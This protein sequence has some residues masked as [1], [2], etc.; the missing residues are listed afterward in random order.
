MN[1]TT[2]LALLF[3]GLG[4]CATPEPQAPQAP[5]AGPDGLVAVRSARVDELFLRP[6]NEMAG[7]RKVLLDPVVVELDRDWVNQRHGSNYRIQ[8]TYPRYKAPEEVTRETTAA[9]SASLAKA[10]RASGFEVVETPGAD[11]MRISAKVS[12]LFINA[13]DVVSPGYARNATRDAGDAYLSLDARDSVSGKALARVQH[14]SIA[15][16]TPRGNIANDPANAL[17]METLFQRWADN[18]ATEL[19][20]ASRDSQASLKN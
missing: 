18:C 2:L 12:D 15:R 4:G 6:G 8:P 9:V 17:W 19:G 5:Q 7:Y 11:V 13:P 1:R 14:H 16:E 3:I 10:F 20:L